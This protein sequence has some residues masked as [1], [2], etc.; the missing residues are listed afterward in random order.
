VEP[1]ATIPILIVDREPAFRT[2]VASML[3]EDGHRV[4]ECPAIEELLPG[5]DRLGH[6]A[7]VLA[8][9]EMPAQNG[10]W[11]ADRIHTANPSARTLLLVSYRPLSIDDEVA[12]RPFVRLVEK[13][14]T[15]DALHRL[16]HE[17][18]DTP[19]D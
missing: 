4:I 11:L 13:P 1:C 7:V 6:I 18:G 15:Y 12:S 10:L 9:H 8:A 19:D 16:I 5:L 17:T 3:R 2:A 14:M